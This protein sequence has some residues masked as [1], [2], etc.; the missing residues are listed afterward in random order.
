MD[1]DGNSYWYINLPHFCLTRIT[2][3]FW[4]DHTPRILLIVVRASSTTTI[5]TVIRSQAGSWAVKALPEK[6]EAASHPFPRG[7]IV[8]DVKG[9][10]CK[11]DRKGLTVAL[12]PPAD[13]SEIKR[14]IWISAG[15]KGVR[16]AADITG[17]RMGRIE[18]GNKIGKVEQVEVVQK[19]C[20]W[21]FYNS[22]TQSLR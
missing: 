22:H 11:A 10:P 4:I 8:I 2:Q 20:R 18:W 1:S 9:R 21:L 15:A 6:T 16:C 5:H 3:S 12:S 14:S 7:S 19:N 13:T 17:E